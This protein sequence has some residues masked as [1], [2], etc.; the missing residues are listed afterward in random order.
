MKSV[1]MSARYAVALSALSAVFVACGGG[2]TEPEGTSASALACVTCRPPPPPPT[3]CPSGWKLC[4]SECVLSSDCCTN[5]DCPP[6]PGDLGGAGSCENFTCN[7]GFEN[8]YCATSSLTNPSDTGTTYTI[9]TGQLCVF[10]SNSC[11]SNADCPAGLLCIAYEY[12]LAT[13]TYCGTLP[14]GY[15]P[16]N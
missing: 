14:V 3:H 12:P 16:V 8:T 5:A 13:Q 4:D 2:D 15:T 6:P 11:C 10:N 7:C 1:K 9:V